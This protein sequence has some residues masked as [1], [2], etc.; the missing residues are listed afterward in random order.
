ML[1]PNFRSQV[2]TEWEGIIQTENTQD[3]CV[4]S[5]ND[6]ALIMSRILM[7]KDKRSS[8]GILSNQPEEVR[9]QRKKLLEV[10]KSYADKNIE[11]RLEG[12]KL[13]STWIR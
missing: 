7:L 4:Y 2:H 6:I 8:I 13:K 5:K 10:Q 12:D 3:M 9:E 11:T 1:W